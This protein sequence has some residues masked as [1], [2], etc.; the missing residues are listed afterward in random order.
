VEEL[1]GDDQSAYTQILTPET[2][3]AWS[4]EVQTRTLEIYEQLLGSES[5]Q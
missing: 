3:T 5:R 1:F 4:P 2:L